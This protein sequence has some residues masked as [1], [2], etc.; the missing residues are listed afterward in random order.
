MLTARI[1]SDRRCFA[2]GFDFIAVNAGSVIV[3][4]WEIP[5]QV[6]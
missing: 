2:T 1:D 3:A 5:K 6:G 4:D